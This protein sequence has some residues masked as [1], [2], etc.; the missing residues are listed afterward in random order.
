MKGNGFL[1][2]VLAVTL[3][4]GGALVAWGLGQS[5]RYQEA[6]ESY[7]DSKDNVE[8]MSRVRPFPTPKSAEERH[9]EI[10]EFRGKVE[11]VQNALQGFRP[12]SLENIAPSEFQNRLVQKT[13]E[14]RNLFEKN[15]IGYPEQFALGFE[16]YRE[17]LANQ[18]AT[19]ELNYQLNAMEWM[20]K[21]LAETLPYNIRN[22]RR[23]RL[24]SED[25]QNWKDGLTREMTDLYQ[26]LPIEL[27][28]LAP[29]ASARDFVN[30]LVS[31]NEYFFTVDS[32]AITN[33]NTN[34]PVRGQAGFESEEVV[35]EEDSG[36]G[37]D[38]IFG[39]VDFG[40]EAAEEEAPAEPVEEEA[41]VDTSRILGRVLGDEGV[42]VGLQMR[43]LLFEAAVE[44]P[45]F[46]K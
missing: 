28:F 33:E 8:Q 14:V 26:S 16:R 36:G 10:T 25:G 45:E 13:E 34:A 31:S 40:E 32:I 21:E 15:R 9:T 11:G 17:E 24:P 29:E 37:F 20:F 43:L 22:I 44:I 39:A 19:G 18:N 4:I 35:E 12:E 30:K 38:A 27:V 1:I 46:K 2:A 7:S 23:E 6:L 3:V 5:K 41:P 42:Y